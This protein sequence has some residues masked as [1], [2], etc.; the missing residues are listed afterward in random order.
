[1]T[2][3]RT[4]LIVD[5]D[6][7]SIRIIEDHLQGNLYQTSSAKSGEDAW[8]MLSKSPIGYDV[9]IV[10]RLMEGMDGLEL[11]RKIKADSQ[12]ANL[13]VIIQTGQADTEEFIA[14]LN[15]GAFDFIY[16][17][18]EQELLLYVIENALMD[19]RQ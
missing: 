1:M 6:V 14:A 15:A 5:D 4:I 2:K 18:V 3:N 13:P 8:E 7:I 9:V 16:K 10:D 17:P 12:L 11:T 19:G